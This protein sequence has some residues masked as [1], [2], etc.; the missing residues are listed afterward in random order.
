MERPRRAYQV[1]APDRDPPDPCRNLGARSAQIRLVSTT[2]SVR[3][4]AATATLTQP[5]NSGPTG[6]SLMTSVMVAPVVPHEIDA[7]PMR[8]SPI[9]MVM[10]VYENGS[11]HVWEETPPAHAKPCSRRSDDGKAF[12]RGKRRGSRWRASRSSV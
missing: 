8:R 12:V 4:S 2:P 7:S 10:E 11:G 6:L 1:H 5:T 3:Q 9:S